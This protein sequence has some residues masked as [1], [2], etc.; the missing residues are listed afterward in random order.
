MGHITLTPYEANFDI[1]VERTH[2]KEPTVLF[3]NE[4]GGSGDKI[5]LALNIPN[6]LYVEILDSDDP[7]KTIMFSEPK[8]ALKDP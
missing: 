4:F 1:S 8:L 5:N 2:S 7:T 3:T 6:R